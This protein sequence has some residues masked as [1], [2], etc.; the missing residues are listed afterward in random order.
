MSFVEDGECECLSDPDRH[1][2]ISIGWK[3]LQGL[4]ALAGAENAAKT[5]EKSVAGRERS[6]QR[7]QRILKNIDEYL[8]TLSENGS[9]IEYKEKNVYFH[10]YYPL[11]LTI[12]RLLANI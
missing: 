8:Q 5:M 4:A 10:I 1:M 9:I 11:N 2:I 3:H 6:G 12:I 7:D